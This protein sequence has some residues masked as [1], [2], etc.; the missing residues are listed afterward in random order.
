MPYMFIFPIVTIIGIAVIL[1]NDK[2]IDNSK[3]EKDEDNDDMQEMVY[4]YI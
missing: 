2:N 4:L 1:K 3:C